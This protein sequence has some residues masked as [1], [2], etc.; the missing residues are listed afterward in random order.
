[1]KRGDLVSV[2]M[3]DDFGKPR[4]ALIIQSNQFDQHPTLSIL[5]VTSHL[6]DAPLFRISIEPDEQ[7][8]LEKSSQVMVDKTMTIKRSKLGKV[9]G[10]IPEKTMLEIDRCLALFLGIAK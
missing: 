5:P 1:M 8:K 3:Q 9:F 4:P 7:N 10:V 6:V 2:T